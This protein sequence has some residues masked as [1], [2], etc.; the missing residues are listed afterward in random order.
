MT[1]LN[2]YHASWDTDTVLGMKI[3][4]VS[5]TITKLDVR[6]REAAYLSPEQLK[7]GKKLR[8]VINKNHGK[9]SLDNHEIE[10]L[11]QKSN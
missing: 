4:G 6:T 3:P 9:A 7:I 5:E 8:S 10:M 11:M 2:L 1:F